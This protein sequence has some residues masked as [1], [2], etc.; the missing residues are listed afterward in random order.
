MFATDRSR[1]TTVI[2]EGQ[3]SGMQLMEFKLTTYQNQFFN[4]RRYGHLKNLKLKISN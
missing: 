2:R 1:D 4:F 3:L